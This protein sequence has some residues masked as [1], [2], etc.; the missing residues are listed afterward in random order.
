M[1]QRRVGPLILAIVL[2]GIC[3]AA[4][5]FFLR[6]IFYPGPVSNFFFKPFDVGFSPFTVNLG[7]F[8]FTLGLS[9]SIT[10]FTVLLILVALYLLYKFF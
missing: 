1:A 9:L 4:L 7:F 8:T 10:V 2:G 3:G 6:K 5:S